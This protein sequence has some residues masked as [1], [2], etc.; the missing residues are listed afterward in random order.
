MSGQEKLLALATYALKEKTGHTI[1]LR[2]VLP[3]WR[4][5][6]LGCNYNPV[7]FLRAQEKD[8]LNSTEHGVCELTTKG[9]SHLHSLLSAPEGAQTKFHHSAGRL[10][11]IERKGTFTADKLLTQRFSAAQR[12]ILVAD[13]YVSR[14][15]L[16]VILTGTS[17]AVIIKVLFGRDDSDF[18]PAATKW[19]REFS[20][21]E[22][23]HYKYLHDRFF[24]V[25][26]KGFILGPSI[27]DAAM[28]H[29]ALLVELGGEESLL[30]TNFFK[31]LWRLGKSSNG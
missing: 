20:K 13:S 29:P 4:K 19:R 28:N 6:S 7:F 27:K 2:D 1:K 5:S 31:G 26:G 10:S 22:V 14:G 18:L 12:D 16:D 17:D 30:L 8:W 3:G 21:L 15:T 11:I 24:V 25:D 23:L 9:L